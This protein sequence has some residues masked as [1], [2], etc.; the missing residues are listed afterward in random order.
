MSG[1]EIRRHT[2][3]HAGHTI[4]DQFA[5]ILTLQAERDDWMILALEL[6]ALLHQARASVQALIETRNELRAALKAMAR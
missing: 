6:N 4:D 2:W 1:T 3:R 5:E